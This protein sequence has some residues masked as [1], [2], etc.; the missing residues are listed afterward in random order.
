MHEDWT[1]KKRRH[2]IHVLNYSFDKCLKVYTD[3]L[4]AKVSFSRLIFTNTFR[5]EFP[6]HRLLSTQG[7]SFLNQFVAILEQRRLFSP[8]FSLPLWHIFEE[9]IQN[10]SVPPPYNYYFLF[11][12]P[13]TCLNHQFTFQDCHH[14]LMISARGWCVLVHMNMQ[15]G[16]LTLYVY[17]SKERVAALVFSCIICTHFKVPTVLLWSIILDFSCVHGVK[18]LTDNIT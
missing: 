18:D 10:V 11:F 3:I 1:E 16:T 2:D 12:S 17:P 15:V 6:Y 9:I 14:R 5:M 4:L 8:M 7:L 13:D